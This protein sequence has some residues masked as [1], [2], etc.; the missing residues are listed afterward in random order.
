MKYVKDLLQSVS[1][2]LTALVQKNATVARPISVGD[3]H[4]LTL[5]ELRLGLGG[6]GG[7]GEGTEHGGASGKGTGLGAGGGARA[8]PV[9]VI[10]IENGKARVQSLGN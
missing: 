9:A 4:V 7:E 8:T 10:I 2:R 6:G 1:T 3:R 5:C